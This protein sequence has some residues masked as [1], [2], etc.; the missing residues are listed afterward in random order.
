M[1]SERDLDELSSH[2]V[3]A[4]A[5]V[6]SSPD[7]ELVGHI[8]EL[9]MDWPKLVLSSDAVLTVREEEGGFRVE[10]CGDSVGTWVDGRR[11]D[12][13]EHVALRGGELITVGGCPDSAGRLSGGSVLLFDPNAAAS[14]RESG[15]VELGGAQREVAQRP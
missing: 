12:P 6:L 11:L 1:Q 10:A 15:I 8:F 3:S 7:S 9:G 4:R 2:V 13:G 14:P 5:I